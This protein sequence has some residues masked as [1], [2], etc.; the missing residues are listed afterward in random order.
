MFGERVFIG[1]IVVLI[2][3]ITESPEYPYRG[4]I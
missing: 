2:V 3:P 1:I 4:K